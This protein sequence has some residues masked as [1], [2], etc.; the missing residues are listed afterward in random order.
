MEQLK[1]ERCLEFRLYNNDKAKRLI[2]VLK[3]K[4]IDFVH[5]FDGLY[6]LFRVRQ[7]GYKW[8]DIYKI[9]NS[10]YAPKY[11]FIKTCI[12]DGQEYEIIIVRG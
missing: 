12:K 4:K 10:V 9:V 5:Y 3:E 11:K 1:N 7:S 6:E 8:E 2:E